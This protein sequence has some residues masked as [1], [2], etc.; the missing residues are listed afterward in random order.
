MAAAA[1]APAVNLMENQRNVNHDELFFERVRYFQEFLESDYGE[2]EVAET[3]LMGDYLPAFD[4]ALKEVIL[5]RATH[6]RDLLETKAFYV[7]IEGSFGAHCV[8]PRNFTSSFLGKMICI[9][10]IVRDVWSLVRPK[11]TKSIHYAG[12]TSEFHERLYSDGLSLGQLIPTG[13]TYPKEDEH[14]NKLTT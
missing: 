8:N 3:T 6:S 11:V 14:G 9:E 5:A 7:G 12:K 2:N 4:Y 10:G 1:F 13:S